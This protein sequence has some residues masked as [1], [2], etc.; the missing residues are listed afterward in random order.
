MSALH[1]PQPSLEALACEALA[2]ARRALPVLR[3]IIS[4]RMFGDARAQALAVADSIERRDIIKSCVAWD[5][6][7]LIRQIDAEIEGMIVQVTMWSDH[8]CDVTGN[9]WIETLWTQE[10]IDMAAARIKLTALCEAIDTVID[11]HELPK[12]LRDRRQIATPAGST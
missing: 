10:A 6:T 7:D 12:M 8:D 9:T 1:H 3:G 5:L 4:E 11:H 2:Q